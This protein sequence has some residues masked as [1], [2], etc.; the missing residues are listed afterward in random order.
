MRIEV[1]ESGTGAVAMKIYRLKR[2]S[3]D[4]IA[5]ALRCIDR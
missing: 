4:G 2:S 1:N 5:I 3:L